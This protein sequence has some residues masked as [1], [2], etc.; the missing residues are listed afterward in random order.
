MS[1]KISDKCGYYEIE[2]TVYAVNKVDFATIP[3][4][5]KNIWDFGDWRGSEEKIF[6]FGIGFIDEKQMDRHDIAEEVALAI[7]NKTGKYYK[8][9]L[10]FYRLKPQ[11]PK[12]IVKDEGDFLK[13]C[14][15]RK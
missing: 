1:K 3:L 6:S 4:A 14:L 5:L 9:E 13:L 2:I 11:K 12:T 8:I 10:D 15:K 7:W